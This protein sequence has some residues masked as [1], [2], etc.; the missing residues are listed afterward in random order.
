MDRV[1]HNSARIGPRYPQVVVLFG[2]TGD[3]SRRKLL[4]GLLHLVSAGFI[5]DCRIIGV[6]LDDIDAASFREIARNAVEQSELRKGDLAGHW[7][8][9]AAK[10]DYVPLSAGPARLR[11]VVDAAKKSQSQK[12]A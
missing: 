8:A 3:L 11:E 9:F 2:A 6:S 4:P 10:L 5:P 1:P 12:G 7:D